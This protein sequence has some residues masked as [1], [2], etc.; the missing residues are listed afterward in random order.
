MSTGTRPKLAGSGYDG[1]APTAT[2]KRA[3]RS[4]AVRREA[5]SPACPPQAMLALEIT[6]NIASSSAV[7][8]PA[9]V[10]PRSAFRSIEAIRRAQ[11]PTRRVRSEHAPGGLRLRKGIDPADCAR[12]RAR[13]DGPHAPILR[14]RRRRHPSCRSATSPSSSEPSTAPSTPSKASTSTS[15]A[16]ETLA[17]V[18]ESGSGKST[19]AM[20]VIGLLPG[21][22]RV[23]QGQ[24]PLRGRGPGR[25]PGERDAQQSAARQIGLVP[26]DPMS[27]LNPGRQDRY[28]GRRDAAR[29]RSGHAQ[30]R[31]PQGGRDARAAGLPDAAE[32]AKQYPHEFSGGMR[33]RA[34]IAIGLAC[35]PKLLIADEPTSALDVTVQRTILDQLERMTGEL[36]TAL[37]LITHDLGL[38]AERAVARRRDAPRRIV[39]QGPARQILEDP[40][41]PYTQALVKAAPSVAAVRLRPE[42]FRKLT[43]EEPR[44]PRPVPRR[45]RHAGGRRRASEARRHR[46]VARRITSSR[47]RASPRCSRSAAAKRT[48]PP[49]TTCRSRSP[50]A[51][52]SRSSA[53]RV[54]AR[55]RPR[56]WCSRSS[57]RPRA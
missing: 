29:P 15:A 25:R 18:G 21:N 5:A 17:I 49:S 7:G 42:A 6:A 23:D 13:Q 3:A 37:M 33:Q 19:T 24:H 50:A 1:C 53:S 57:T 20:A 11:R 46:P 12:A 27:N 51:K 4:T 28:A 47:S 35:N 45:R 22:G 41:E 40:Q 8:T 10:S 26:Q 55:R 34:L 54:R 9:T 52:R 48:S 2:P 36:G 30:E 32:R 31:R 38:A 14:A 39:E 56:A 16:G 43:S 44:M